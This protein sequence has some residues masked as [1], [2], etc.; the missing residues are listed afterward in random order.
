MDENE[1]GEAPAVDPHHD[2]G[3]GEEDI[4]LL[5]VPHVLESVSDAVRGGAL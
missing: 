3:I 1:L 4:G 2:P 5:E